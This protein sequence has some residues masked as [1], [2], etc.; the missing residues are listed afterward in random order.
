VLRRV[1]PN[2]Y[3]GWIVV[4]AF[5]SL[6]VMIG[7][8]FFYGFGTIF[9][10]VIEDFGWSNA[11]VSLAFS[12]RSE[13]GGIAAPIVGIMIDRFGP[14]RS[15]LSGVIVAALGVFGLAF[16]QN[17]WQFYLGMFVIALG[18]SACGGPVGMV[19]T[20][21]W[22][23]RRRALALSYLTVGGAVAGLGVPVVAWLV[24]SFGWRDA[25]RA[26]A[27]AILVVGLLVSANVRGRPADHPQPMDGDRATPHDDATPV[28]RMWGVPAA[29]VMRSRAFIMLS[30]SQAAVGFGTT[31]LIVHVIPYL[32]GNG[33]SKT[34]AAS[35]VTI[36]TLFSLVGR[37]GL[38]YLADRWDKRLIM[39]FSCLLVAV[40]MPLL[41]FTTA[42][43][44]T[45]AVLLLI[46]PGF[47]GTIPVRPAILADYFG[48]KYFGAV[49]GGMV[50]VQTLGAF[51]GPW[52][53]GWVVDVTGHYTLGWFACAAVTALAVPLALLATPP[54]HLQRRYGAEAPE[55]ATPEVNPA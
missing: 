27:V 30:L 40:G 36:Y 41:A 50:F 12:L 45:M 15:L 25:L 31:A 39:A 22:F 33:I 28:R 9:K 21:T 55:G 32:E 10:P 24:E 53:V 35:A 34:S 44:P 13:V 47:G 14:R 1:F 4:G 38:G 46:A 3:E 29:V 52:L 16:M 23:E 2:V 20:A 37:L 43:L 49:N 5:A 42:L 26:L 54:R 6:V 19:A 17:L 18:V 48:T 7:T 8:A 51:F 11:E